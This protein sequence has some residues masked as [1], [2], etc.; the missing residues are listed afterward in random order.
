MRSILAVCFLIALAG[1]GTKVNRPTGATLDV[2]APWP[3]ESGAAP[4]E[5]P[6]SPEEW[7]SVRPLLPDLSTG[8][9]KLWKNAVPRLTI[10]L[11]GADGETVAEGTFENPARLRMTFPDHTSAFYDVSPRLQEQLVSIAKA[12]GYWK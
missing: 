10:I 5:I 7:S 8:E 9:R 12:H 11:V 3:P 4:R 2:Y 6:L 1:C